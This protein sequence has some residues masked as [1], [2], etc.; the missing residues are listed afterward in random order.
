MT[1]VFHTETYTHK[2]GKQYMVE[3]SY[4]HGMGAPQKEHPDCHGVVVDLDFDPED[5]GAV[6]DYIERTTEEDSTEELEERARMSV[7]RKLGNGGYRY[8]GHQ[9]YYDVWASM[10]KAREVWGTAEENV[11]AAVDKDYEYMDGWYSDDWHWCVTSVYALD[12][13][14][15]KDEDT[16]HHCG[17]YE[18]SITDADQRAWFEEVIEDGISQVEYEL[19]RELH[20]N[21]LE[22]ALGSYA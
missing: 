22:L 16:A 12:E 3:L 15:E 9:R 20:K 7:M 19:K 18:S 17:G 14:G 4:D 13:D 8:G 10:K 5:E 11:Q 6:D 2:N 21:Q 1:D